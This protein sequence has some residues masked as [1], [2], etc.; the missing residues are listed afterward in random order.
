MV[1]VTKMTAYGVNVTTSTGI[2]T[3]QFGHKGRQAHISILTE[4]CV[5]WL[6]VLL[7]LDEL[8]SILLKIYFIG[9]TL[10]VTGGTR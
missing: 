5:L 10:L 6:N 7:F 4:P 9:A 8:G 3:L 1:T 2:A